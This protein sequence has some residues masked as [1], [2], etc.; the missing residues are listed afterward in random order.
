ML[1]LSQ[2]HIFDPQKINIYS[3]QLFRHV[4]PAYLSSPYRQNLLTSASELAGRRQTHYSC[5]RWR[6]Y[7]LILENTSDNLL[8]V[9]QHETWSYIRKKLAETQRIEE[10]RG[11]CECQSPQVVTQS[12]DCQNQ[13]W[14]LRAGG[15]TPTPF[16]PITI[17][18]KVAVYVETDRKL[19]MLHQLCGF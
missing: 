18:Y 5:R 19:S 8:L 14:L 2:Y 9:S 12:G 11:L 15:C 17:T 3:A 1:I 4:Q 16:Q 6:P 13:P 10:V 7:C